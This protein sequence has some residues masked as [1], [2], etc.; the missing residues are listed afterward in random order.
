MC[1]RQLDSEPLKD[2]SAATVNAA[3]EKMLDIP[4][5]GQQVR[6]TTDRGKEFSS[7]DGLR[8]IVHNQGPIIKK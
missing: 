6:L 4:E 2:K 5:N 1:T 8:G 3:F 7:I